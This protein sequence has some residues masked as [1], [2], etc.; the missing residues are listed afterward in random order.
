MRAQ[1]RIP[2]A[3]LGAWALG[4]SLALSSCGRKTTQ[5]EPETFPR[6]VTGLPMAVA[7]P[8]LDV[9]D[10]EA[11]ELTA[12][13]VRKM[14]NGREVRMLGYNGSVPGPLI[15]VRQGSH[16]RVKLTNKLGLP[17]T[18]HSHGVRLNSLSD[19]ASGPHPV[20]D[21]DGFTYDVKFPDPGIYWYHGHYREDYSLEHGLYGNYLVVPADTAYWKPADREVVLIIQDLLLDEGGIAPFRKDQAGHVLMGRFGNVFLVNGDTAHALEVKRKEVVRFFVTN[22]CN[23]RALYLGVKDKDMRVVGSDNGAFEFP[24]YPGRELVSP[25]ERLVFEAQFPDSGADVLTHAIVRAQDPQARHFPLVSIKVLPDS[26]QT[27]YHESFYIPDGSPQ[28]RASIDSVRD[29]LDAPPGRELLLTMRMDH[30]AMKRSATQHDPALKG[31]EWEDDMAGMNSRSTP[32]SVTWIIR[33]A[34][35]GAE[36]HAIDWTFERGERAI[37]RIVNDSTA[38]HPMPHPIHFHG[39]RFLVL[40]EDGETIANM[41]WKDTY[42]IGA[43]STVD[44][45]LEA[46][47]P[48][49]WMAHCHI[50]GHLEAHMMFNFIV[51]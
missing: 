23:T 41:A 48:G 8:T 28:A 12:A 14:V 51:K 27:G 33:D 10:G 20:A 18:L 46:A 1:A 15:R 29:R 16:I 50:A 34:K 39:Q 24:Y 31:V 30:G 25:G 40:R 44:I 5:P 3:G 35:T 13:P 32:S 26:A 43:K 2:T 11:V 17:T 37:I 42:L 21:G 47:N 49:S 38:M 22:A 45:L 6:D 9:A 4:L 7:S 36:N 19:G